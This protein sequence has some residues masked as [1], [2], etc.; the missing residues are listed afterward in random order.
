MFGTSPTVKKNVLWKLW[1]SI[2]S[3][4]RKATSRKSQ[5]FIEGKACSVTQS[6]ATAVA[7]YMIVNP[8][9][10][11]KLARY[12]IIVSRLIRQHC[13]YAARLTNVVS[14]A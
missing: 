11:K 6:A 8:N 13:A 3:A 10:M 14:D 1:P 7:W 5:P 2:H 12:S 4:Y 9:H